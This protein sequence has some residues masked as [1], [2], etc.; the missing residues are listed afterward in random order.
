[1]F[2]GFGP[3]YKLHRL[4]R[5]H[6][7][8]NLSKQWEKK[9]KRSVGREASDGGRLLRSSAVGRCEPHQK[10]KEWGG[11]E[12]AELQWCWVERSVMCVIFRR[13]RSMLKVKGIACVGGVGGCVSGFIFY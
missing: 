3:I 6:H 1:M 5:S 2:V 11:G 10:P 7:Q 12:R 13:E 9:S 8:R 4:I